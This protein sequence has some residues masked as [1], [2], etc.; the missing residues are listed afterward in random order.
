MGDPAVRL[1]TV[2]ALDDVPDDVHVEVIDGVLVE[3]AMTSCEHGD[4]Q[5]SLGSELKQ[6]FR[7]RGP[8]GRGGWWIATEVTVE[9]DT[10]QG[11]RHD[12][13]GWRKDRVP[14]RPAARRVKV[15]PDWVCEILS[16]NKQKDLVEKRRVLHEKGVPHSWILD[17]EGR[18]LSV[19]RHHPEGFLLV[20][21]VS[22]GQTA[23]L[24]PFDS[25]ELETSKLF[26]DLDESE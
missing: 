26:G 11:Y 3:E 21:A 8:E 2:D 16:T 19:Y 4:A 5:L 7:G 12:L 13:A 14:T 24:E 10:T 17:P 9:Y 18:V 23:R 20:T 25:V 1:V 6:R 22:P 15:R